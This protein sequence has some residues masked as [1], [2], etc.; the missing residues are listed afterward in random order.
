MIRSGG[1]EAKDNTRSA[2]AA[3][4][5]GMAST[6]IA[7]AARRGMAPASLADASADNEDATN[8]A[9]MCD[10]LEETRTSLQGEYND[11]DWCLVWW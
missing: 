10:E 4:M 11:M 7:A 9:A 5:R 1:D 2:A 3:A 8:A 6:S